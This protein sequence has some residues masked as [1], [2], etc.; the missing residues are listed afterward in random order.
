MRLELNV[1][2][3]VVAQCF[4]ELLAGFCKSL[5]LFIVVKLVSE[6]FNLI[7][8]AISMR[9]VAIS[10]KKVASVV[11]F[12]PVLSGAVFQNITLLLETLANEG[13]HLLEPF[14]QLWIC[15]SISVDS[16]DGID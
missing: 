6:E 3:T 7:N 2:T 12:V 5:V 4:E 14:L 10:E 9:S 15:I 8:D 16:V 11:K 1:T 13:V